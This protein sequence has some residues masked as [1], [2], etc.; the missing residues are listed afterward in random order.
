MENLIAFYTSQWVYGW[1]NM[2]CSPILA[3]TV[4]LRE[5]TETW[6]NVYRP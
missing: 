1:M 5:F 2:I 6:T 3:S 4:V